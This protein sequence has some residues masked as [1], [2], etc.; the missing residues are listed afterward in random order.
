MSGPELWVAY[1]LL[2]VHH[3]PEVFPHDGDPHQTHKGMDPLS[4]SALKHISQSVKSFASVYT[5]YPIHISSLR[6]VIEKFAYAFWPRLMYKPHVLLFLP[7]S[8]SY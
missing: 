8:F 1:H 6:D 5:L 7:P 2:V 4:Q 3:H